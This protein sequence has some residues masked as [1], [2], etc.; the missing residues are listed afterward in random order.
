MYLYALAKN[1]EGGVTKL[2]FDDSPASEAL[3]LVG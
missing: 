3:G 1:R 2:L